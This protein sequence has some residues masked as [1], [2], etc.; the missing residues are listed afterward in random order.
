MDI[1]FDI[2]PTLLYSTDMFIFFSVL[3]NNKRR[4]NHGFILDIVIIWGIEMF[5]NIIFLP[6]SGDISMRATVIRT[7]V[8]IL[9][10]IVISFLFLSKLIWRLCASLLF[11]AIT[12]L[13]ENMAFS[14]IN[15]FMTVSIQ[16]DSISDSVFNSVFSL[17]DF[18]CL[19]F[20]LI[21]ALIFKRI[22]ISLSIVDI[23]TILI[24]PVISMIITITPGIFELNKINPKSYSN[25]VNLLIAVNIVNFFMINEISKKEELQSQTKQ[26][27]RQIEFQQNK[28]VQLG[29]SYKSLRSFMHDTKKHFMYI[30]DCINKKN[31]DA[32]I[33]YTKDTLDDLSSR[34]CSVNTGNLVIDSFVSNLKNVADKYHI[35][36]DLSIKLTVSQI[37]L[38]D[39]D[40]TIVLGNLFDNA[41]SACKD[42]ENAVITLKLQIIRN[43]FTVYIENSYD[44]SRPH[45][46][47]NEFDFIHGYGLE[48]VKKAVAKYNG[49]CL[50]NSENSLY[51]V[52]CIVPLKP[53]NEV[54]Y[55]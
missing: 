24:I 17:S 39:Y 42:I 51:T 36:L 40:L 55:I 6:L 32:V 29:E 52:T 15:H 47:D 12:T 25:L 2:I 27:S 14:T 11:M 3:F 1:I 9:V 41:I 10:N 21:V 19:I 18:Y 7:S 16:D 49:F 38:S 23:S 4:M 8:S 46:S 20:V 13:C 28:Y 22:R 35:T 50:I 43:T 48:N 26:L 54:R 30:Q 44:E 34:Y 37:P 31:Y 5:L 33:P 45:P 53:V